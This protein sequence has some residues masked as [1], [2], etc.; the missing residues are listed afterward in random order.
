MNLRV[1]V[2]HCGNHWYADIDDRD[3]PQPDDPFWYVDNCRSQKQ[4]LEAA[5]AELLMLS[6]RVCHGDHL[7]RVLEAAVAA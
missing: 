4:A 5:C 1:R 2:L 7:Y 3:D 6:N